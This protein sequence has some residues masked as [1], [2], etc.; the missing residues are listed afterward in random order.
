MAGCETEPTWGRPSLAEVESSA[1]VAS[2]LP[3]DREYAS[4]YSRQSDFGRGHLDGRVN[5]HDSD[6]Q[7][8]ARSY[9]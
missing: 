1:I 6:L 5:F 2:N 4:A 7:K 8:L 9:F 3:L